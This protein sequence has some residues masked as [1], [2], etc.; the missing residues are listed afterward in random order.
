VLLAFSFYQW[1]NGIEEVSEIYQ[2]PEVTEILEFDK[3]SIQKNNP[4]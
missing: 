1:Q 3:Q 2:I 4:R